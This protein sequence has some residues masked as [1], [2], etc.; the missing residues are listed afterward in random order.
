MLKECKPLLTGQ[1]KPSQETC[2]YYVAS[3]LVN[4]DSPNA[5][6]SAKLLHFDSG[7]LGKVAAKTKGS[8]DAHK[9]AFI[10][11]LKIWLFIPKTK[12]I[13]YGDSCLKIT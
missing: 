4:A 8:I 2:V 3:I 13:R 11:S 6:H 5:W 12:C 9:N 1:S 7:F 10:V